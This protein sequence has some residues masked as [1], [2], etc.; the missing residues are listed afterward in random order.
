MARQLRNMPKSKAALTSARTAANSIY[1]P[2]LLQAQIDTQVTADR[3]REESQRRCSAYTHASSWFLLH[4]CPVCV[5][6]ARGSVSERG[7]GD[8]AVFGLGVSE[9]HAAKALFLAGG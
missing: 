2:P 4:C 7:G 8:E 1:C 9:W 5:G 3:E 6:G